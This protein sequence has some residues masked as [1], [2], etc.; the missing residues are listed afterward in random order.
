MQKDFDNWNRKKKQINNTASNKLYHQRE[1][2][3][4]SLGVNVGY[5]QDGKG[6]NKERPVLILRGFSRHVCLAVPLTTSA[7]IN[8]FSIPIGMMNGRQNWAIISQVRL[9]DT[10]RLIN[11]ICTLDGNIFEEIRKA[12]RNL[13]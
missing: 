3:W 2:W 9:I 11:K 7:K 10:K 5:E 6:D 4:C 1:V 13:F 12:V 8:P